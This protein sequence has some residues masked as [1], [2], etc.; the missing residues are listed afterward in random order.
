MKWRQG[1]FGRRT[2][3][4]FQC[5]YNVGSSSLH[6]EINALYQP[7]ISLLSH[8]FISITNLLRWFILF[9][10]QL[11]QRLFRHLPAAHSTHYKPNNNISAA[12]NDDC[13]QL[14][15]VMILHEH[16]YVFLVPSPNSLTKRWRL[17][18]LQLSGAHSVKMYIYSV[19][20]LK[21]KIVQ[22]WIYLNQRKHFC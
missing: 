11:S 16:D 10:Q 4:Y 17:R 8:H 1:M 22:F 3:G 20:T 15:F 12:E 18:C 5:P 21:R 13:N 2:N 14:L 6:E 7:C 19:K 9:L